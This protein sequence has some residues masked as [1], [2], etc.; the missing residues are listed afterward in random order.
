MTTEITLEDL[1]VM[2]AR[3]GLNLAEEELRKLLPG[4]NRAHRQVAELREFV[5]DT[6]EPAGTF[7]ASRRECK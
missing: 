1:R 6:M 5:T 3:A 7:S 2:A 4:V